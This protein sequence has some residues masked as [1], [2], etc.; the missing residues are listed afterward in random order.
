[1]E[2]LS[3]RHS[4]TLSCFLCVCPSIRV[5]QRGISNFLLGNDFRLTGA[6]AEAPSVFAPKRPFM[7]TLLLSQQHIHSGSI[8]L[9]YLLLQSTKLHKDQLNVY[10][11]GPLQAV[12]GQTRMEPW[13]SPSET[14]GRG[15]ALRT[16]GREDLRLRD[17]A[18]LS[19]R[20]GWSR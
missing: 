1:M 13:V 10:D 19:W 18:Q 4:L 15:A 14:T 20:C 17:S 2:E 6:G 3:V 11:G 5:P 16:L 9:A 7:L 12:R 8:N